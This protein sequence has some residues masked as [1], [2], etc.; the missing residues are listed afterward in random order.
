MDDPPSRPMVAFVAPDGSRCLADCPDTGLTFETHSPA[1]TEA[2]ARLMAITRAE[3]RSLP[4]GH[5]TAASAAAIVE[6]SALTPRY[7]PWAD[8]NPRSGERLRLPAPNEQLPVQ[9]GAV[10]RDR[11]SGRQF[12]P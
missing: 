5:L 10:L 2:A 11:R 3:G 7:E 12:G 1:A 6:A 8:D 4:P 9:L